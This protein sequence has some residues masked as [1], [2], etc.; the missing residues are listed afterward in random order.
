MKFSVMQLGAMAGAKG[1]IFWN[2]ASWISYAAAM[3]WD[4]LSRG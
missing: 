1:D 3:T 2:L 4:A